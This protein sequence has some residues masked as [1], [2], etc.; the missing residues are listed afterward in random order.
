MFVLKKHTTVIIA[1]KDEQGEKGKHTGMSA[2]S[3]SHVRGAS[4]VAMV[5][6]W[7]RGRIFSLLVAA[8]KEARRIPRVVNTMKSD[9]R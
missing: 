6:H 2:Q 8:F 7:V 5:E 4:I 1:A 9:Y 3:Q